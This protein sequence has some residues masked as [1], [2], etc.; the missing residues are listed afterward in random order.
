ME[1]NT[2]RG[3]P[4]AIEWATM[5]L[6]DALGRELG[7]DLRDENLRETPKRVSRMYREILAGVGET[8]K[9][10]EDIL[11]STFPCNNDHLIVVRDIEIF[12]ICPHHLL[13]VH[14]KLHLGYLPQERVIGVSKLVRLA[15]VLAKRPVL[16]EQLVDDIAKNLM[17][18][19][20]ALG[21]GCIAEASHYCMVMRGVKQADSKTVTSSLKGAFL[22]QGVRQ[23]F[24]ELT[25]RVST[26][27]R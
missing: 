20:G 27:V 22:E 3:K 2:D 14:Y 24:M 13:P 9:K 7:L 17:R 16:Q 19:D 8:D 15:D 11:D 25:R 6:L 5:E 12:S 23:E 1:A 18:I 26:N 4:D 21:A 10:V